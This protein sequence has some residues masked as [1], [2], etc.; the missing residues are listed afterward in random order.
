MFRKIAF[1][2]DTFKAI[3]SRLFVG[4]RCCEAD[5]RIGDLL[6]GVAR[7][8]RPQQNSFEFSYVIEAGCELEV[9]AIL[10][11]G[12]YLNWLGSGMTAELELRGSRYDALKSGKFLYGESVL[13]LFEEVQI[14]GEGKFHI[15]CR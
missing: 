12:K 4:G 2:I 3:K 10:T 9:V 13:P 1:H 6:T 11:Y 5:I 8:E 15:D 7:I 14:L